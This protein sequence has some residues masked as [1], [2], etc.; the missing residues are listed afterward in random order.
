MHG[1]VL[2]S[3]MQVRVVSLC[4]ILLVSVR[5]GGGWGWGRIFTRGGSP[6]RGRTCP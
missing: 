1:T 5:N 6:L 2:I 3:C 4:H